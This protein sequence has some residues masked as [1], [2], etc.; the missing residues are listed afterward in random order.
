MKKLV[1]DDLTVGQ[2]VTILHGPMETVVMPPMMLGGEAPPSVDTA[3]PGRVFMIEAI[4]MNT[5]L[6][7]L[8]AIDGGGADE[9]K[10]AQ[11]GPL[12]ALMPQRSKPDTFMFKLTDIEL[13]A[14][15]PDWLTAYVRNFCSHKGGI[16]ELSRREAR[17]TGTAAKGQVATSEGT[18][19]TSS[20]AAS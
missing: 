7:M 8:K 6:I 9:Q 2:A 16:G 15:S 5:G 11:M 12:M 10:L 17:K 3:V 19:G 1:L 4:D 13:A 20:S 14:V 18:N